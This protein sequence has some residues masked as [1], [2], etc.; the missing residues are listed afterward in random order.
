VGQV[1]LDGEEASWN[2]PQAESLSDIFHQDWHGIAGE[3]DQYKVQP[4]N[5]QRMTNRLC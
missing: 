3:T 2:L 1:R 4:K 5:D